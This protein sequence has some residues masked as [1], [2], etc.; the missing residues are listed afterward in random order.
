MNS[1]L[2]KPVYAPSVSEDEDEEIVQ[3]VAESSIQGSQ[4]VVIHAAVPSYGQR[5]GWKPTSLED[6][7]ASTHTHKY[8]VKLIASRRWWCIPGMSCCPV[9]LG[10][11]Q[12]EGASVILKGE[13]DH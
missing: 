2:P 1:L 8:H 10:Y 9:S 11:G 6:F 3:K 5:R 4:S 7:G 13:A 12:E